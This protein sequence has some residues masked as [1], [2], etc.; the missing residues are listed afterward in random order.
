MQSGRLAGS[1]ETG[2]TCGTLDRLGEMIWLRGIA[3][4]H[5]ARPLIADILDGKD[6][7]NNP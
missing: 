4:V 2:C 1:P 7:L 6:R 5:L 3:G